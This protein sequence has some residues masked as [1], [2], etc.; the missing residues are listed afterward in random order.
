MSDKDKDTLGQLK[1]DLKLL[2]INSELVL[3][4]QRISRRKYNENLAKIYLWWRRAKQ[5]EGYLESEFASSG[6]P[7][8]E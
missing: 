3:V 4:D 2:Q 7:L 6:S 8:M 1:S 5:K